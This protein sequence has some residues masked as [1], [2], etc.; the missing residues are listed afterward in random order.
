MGSISPFA[1]LWISQALSQLG[2]SIST[3]AYPLLIL[4]NSGS[5]LEAGL[6][7]AV[8]AA[9]G[10][11]LRI[12]GGVLADR[13]RYRAVMLFADGARAAIVGCLAL[14]I[15]VGAYSLPLVLVIVALEVAFGVVFGPAEFA[16]VRRVVPE[17]DRALAV[18][19]MQSRSHLAGL[20]GPL[21]GGVLFGI[22][23]A[24]P[25]AADALSY[26]VSFACVV[27]VRSSAA[28]AARGQASRS[29]SEFFAGI[30]WVW[31]QRALW[32]AG[33]WVAALT[34]VFGAVGLAL[35]VFA[36]DRGSTSAE[37]GVMFAISAGGGLV[38]ALATPW[39][40]RRLRPGTIFRTAALVNLAATLALLPLSSP[41]LIGI[42]G[43]FAFFLAPAVAASLF[44]EVSAL[45]PDQLVGR[46]QSAMTLIVGTI[47]PFTPALIGLVI[48]QADVATGVVAC[49]I[50][51]AALAVVSLALP[52]LG[53]S[54]VRGRER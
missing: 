13:F 20:I 31:R 39:L 37:I 4:A 52:A 47:A 3:L 46:A 45:A 8:T 30:R 15:I 6:V 24:L 40:Q 7:G 29:V 33:W 42:V 10:L 32:A 22:H 25:F 38:G 49:A 23:P 26:T 43:A 34:A 28:R 44:G 53:D 19:R 11:A 48:D 50:G 14:A 54:V 35:V 36:K 2:T 16:L 9:T 51:F 27:A 12:P 21:V 41:Y 17:D 1:L 18:G 5:A